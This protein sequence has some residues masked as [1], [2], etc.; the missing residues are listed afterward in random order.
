MTLGHALCETM[1]NRLCMVCVSLRPFERRVSTVCIPLLK[2][3]PKSAL[4]SDYVQY[5]HGYT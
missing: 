2:Q 3:G 1:R 4:L 5:C